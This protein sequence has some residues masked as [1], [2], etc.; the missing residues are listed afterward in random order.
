MKVS[1][2]G[3]KMIQSFEGLRLRAYKDIV[4][5]PTIGYGHTG[6]DVKM[7]MV[8][9]KAQAEEI[10]RVDLAWFEQAV[11]GLIQVKVTQ[12]QFD[13]MVSLTYNIGGNAFADSTLLR[14]F[15]RGDVQGAADE[16]LRWNKAGGKEVQGL[17][18]RR[19][20]E[21]DHFLGSC[22]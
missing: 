7:G 20:R 3:M 17:T 9:T 14:K 19:H 6:K 15:N 11:D 8:I 5:I 18:R 21:R 2:A 4:G 1:T 10:M 16:F 13:A 12:N 22:A